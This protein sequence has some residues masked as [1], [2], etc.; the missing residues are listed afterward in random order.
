MISTPMQDALSEQLNHEFYS[1]YL[2]LAM[3]AYASNSDFNGA[4]T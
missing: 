1:A 4:A 3:A 2:Y